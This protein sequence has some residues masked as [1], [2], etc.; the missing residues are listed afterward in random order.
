M[1]T[2][3]GTVLLTFDVEEFDT[4]LEYGQELTPEE[5][6]AVGFKGFKIVMDVIDAADVPVTLFTTANFAD[7]YPV[8][9]RHAKHHHEIAS[10]TYYHSSFKVE[11]LL[12]SR[13]RLEEICN[14]PVKGLRMPRMRPV[15]MQDVKAA[16]YQYDSSINPTFLPGRYNNLHLPRTTYKEKDVLR[17]PASVTP[18]V[19]L[20]LFWLMFKN[21]P[22]PLF[23]YWARKTLKNDGYICLYFHP[24]EFT[25]ISTYKLPG[26]V[27]RHSGSK[28]V[29]RLHRL[30]TDL[31]KEASFETM[32]DFLQ[33]QM[34]TTATNIPH[35]R[36]KI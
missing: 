33:K 12:S 18:W 24:W 35:F 9:I 21:V 23:L 11:D 19:R 17:V 30:I 34:K 16:G 14:K 2:G 7:R 36:A 5:Q 26:Y 22:Y 28:L 29:D 15:D 25:D 32:N 1:I 13:E 31:K 27:K 4:P 20:P 3:K 8:Y 10:H 6:M